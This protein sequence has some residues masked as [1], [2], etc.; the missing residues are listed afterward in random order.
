MGPRPAALRE[1]PGHSP[2]VW[3]WGMSG[4]WEPGQA[5]GDLEMTPALQLSPGAEGSQRAQLGFPG[6]SRA[7]GDGGRAGAQLSRQLAFRPAPPSR[8]SLLRARQLA[9]AAGPPGRSDRGPG[10]PVEGLCG[11]ENDVRSEASA[12][13]RRSGVAA[14]WERLGPL[15]GAVR[16]RGAGR[17][18]GRSQLQCAGLEGHVFG[19]DKGPSAPSLTHR[20]PDVRAARKPLPQRTRVPLQTSVPESSPHWG[21]L[22]CPLQ[23]T[24]ERDPGARS[25]ALRWGAVGLDVRTPGGTPTEMAQKEP[26]W[27]NRTHTGMHPASQGPLR[28]GQAGLGLHEAQPGAK[29]RETGPVLAE[30]AASL[31]PRGS[32]FTHEL[33]CRRPL[34]LSCGLRL[35]AGFPQSKRS[36]KGGQG[37]APSLRSGDSGSHEG[38]T[39]GKQVTT[40]LIPGT[41]AEH[42]T[43][44]PTHPEAL[45]TMLTSPAP[46]D[47]ETPSQSEQIAHH[48]MGGT[49]HCLSASPPQFW[50][51][52]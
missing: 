25:G 31:G 34:C 3:F 4:P 24:S 52:E 43:L 21:G 45:G 20:P 51:E 14:V 18:P 8:K 44:C 9:G 39:K 12:A 27:T 37:A 11:A 13:E 5:G 17:G 6:Q 22:V 2:Q 46:G 38:Q 33:V 15:M 16:I 36:Q 49:C 29:G 47:V 50:V 48:P 10:L 42:C 28:R 7:A 35:A 41:C 23:L 1:D 32:K 19:K 40:R 30:D 26:F